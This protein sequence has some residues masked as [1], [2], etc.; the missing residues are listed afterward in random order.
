M[1]KPVISRQ[2]ADH[3]LSDAHSPLIQ[4]ILSNRGIREDHQLA[5]GLDQLTDPFLMKGMRLAVD[6]LVEAKA[7]QEKIV[8]MGD[9]DADGATSTALLMRAFQD[10]G[11]NAVSFFVPDRFTFGYGLSE[12]AVD[13]VFTQQTPDLLITVDNG[14]SSI[15]GVKK[16]NSL[17]LDVIVTD[18]HL[19]AQT[20]PNALAIV[21]PNQP[22][23]PFPHKTLAGV[24]VAF[25]LLIALRKALKEA[26]EPI[27]NLAQYLD[28]VA[29]GTVADLVPLDF[30][31]RILVSQG[32]KRIRAGKTCEGI[33]QLLAVSKKDHRLTVSSDLSFSVAPKLNAAGRL[34][35]MTQGIMLLLTDSEG[36]AADLAAD[37]SQL[38]IERRQIETKMQDEAEAILAELNIDESTL[39]KGLCLYH[40]DWHQGVVGLVASRL[41]EK[42]HR[43]VII[44]AEDDEG[45]LKGS[46]RSITGIHLRD[47]LAS[48]DAKNPSMIKAFGG[49]AMAAGLTL[50]SNNH[51]AFKKSFSEALDSVSESHFQ[52]SWLSDG[53]IASK[54]FHLYTAK[55]IRDLLPWGQGMPEPLF[56]NTFVLKQF[57]VVGEK[58]LKLTLASQDN[59]SQLLE[60][61]WFFYDETIEL[62]KDRS[63]HCVYRLQ[64]NYFRDN[65]TLQLQIEQ[66]VSG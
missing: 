21:N 51:D 43:P 6:R 53:A 31:N 48:M 30:C 65:E 54:D 32:L 23:C 7:Q 64:V 16:A 8:I 17:G 19:P 20:L 39:P 50:S 1:L 47:L 3:K 9:F 59:P 44:F 27:V 37:L 63:Y 2:K 58:H 56:D 34:E 14:I 52:A 11:F 29:L 66:M 49:H 33:K 45:H 18:H 60:A 46:G 57:R 12:Q 42:Y 40:P 10:L 62:I 5:Q 35:D 41:K 22:D 15:D 55:Q 61:I 24:G 28:L 13:A 36:F 38:N 26:G 4:H 25:H